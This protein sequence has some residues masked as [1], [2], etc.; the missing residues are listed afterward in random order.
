MVIVC[1][2]VKD[3]THGSSYYCTPSP[4]LTCLGVDFKV[5]V[6]QIN[7]CKICNVQQRAYKHLLYILF[8]GPLKT[9]KHCTSSNPYCILHIH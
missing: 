4:F 5:H 1:A 3:L 7:A 6:P 2:K 9:A 8:V